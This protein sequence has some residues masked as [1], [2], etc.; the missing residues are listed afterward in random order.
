MK[1]AN[2][3]MM[4]V[5]GFFQDYLVVDRGLSQN[6][7][8]AYRDALKLFFAFQCS[9][10]KKSVTK[11]V[12]D[13]VN[14]D[15]VLL[16]LNQ[17]EIKRNNSIV[18]RNLRLASLKTFSLFLTTKDVLRAGEY[19]RIIALPLKKAP[20]K[21]ID[22]LEVNEV[23]AIIGDCDQGNRNEQRDHVLLNL[24]Y[25]T[26]ARV[27]EICDLTVSSITFGRLPVVTL[28]G[29]GNK[30]RRV[31]IWQDTAKLLMDYL[32]DLQ[33]VDKPADKLFLNACGQPLGR[34]GIRYIIKKRVESASENCPTLKKK[35]I[36][37]HTFRHTIAMHLL[38]A[39]V[40]LTIIKS[41]LGHVNLET[42]HAYVEID[43]E[44]KR[45]VLNAYSPSGE[46]KS[47]KGVLDRNNDILAWLESI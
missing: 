19:Q 20:H 12:L 16:F 42:T 45:K 34:F 21:V 10:Q 24:L 14:A 28:V 17:L 25:N 40:D 33:I 44:M 3:L 5:Q 35:S 23:N 47:L 39:G 7:V 8:M 26:G 36:G 41:W 30:T 6:T 29:K 1:K 32:Q 46:S 38:Q 9:R 31:P 4:L 18:T 27:Q 2:T 43:M 37:P 15:A 11:L 22:Y 13:D